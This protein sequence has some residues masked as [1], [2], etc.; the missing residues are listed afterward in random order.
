L[1]ALLRCSLRAK[2]RQWSRRWQVR[3]AQPDAAWGEPKE[4][5]SVALFL[6]SPVASY[7]NG[8]AIIV[9][10]GLSSSHHTAK[11]PCERKPGAPTW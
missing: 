10:D 11:A 6:A 5:A 2:V 7:I 3:P 4:I 9:D 1:A 8:Q